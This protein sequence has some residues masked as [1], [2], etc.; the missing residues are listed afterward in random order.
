[1][2]ETKKEEIIQRIIK[3]YGNNADC[4][5]GCEKNC[6]ILTSEI[7]ST[8]KA[9]SESE[10]ID[11]FKDINEKIDEYK[12]ESL[13]EYNGESD[14]SYI[15][16]KDIE[17]LEYFIKYLWLFIYR[18]IKLWLKPKKI[19]STPSSLTIKPKEKVS[20]VVNQELDDYI[21]EY[22]SGNRDMYKVLNEVYGTIKSHS[23]NI[24]EIKTEAQVEYEATKGAKGYKTYDRT[25]KRLMV[26]PKKN[27]KSINAVKEQLYH[28]ENTQTEKVEA[29]DRALEKVDRDIASGNFNNKPRLIQWNTGEFKMHPSKASRDGAR[30]ILGKARN[31]IAGINKVYA[32]R[33]LDKNTEFDLDTKVRVPEKLKGANHINGAFKS[34]QSTLNSGIPVYTNSVKKNG[35]TQDKGQEAVATRLRKI[36]SKK[37]EG[38]ESTYVEVDNDGNIKPGSNRFVLRTHAKPA[39]T[40]TKSY[41]NKTELIARKLTNNEKLSDDEQEYFTNFKTAI[42]AKQKSF[43]RQ[44][45]CVRQK[46]R[47]GSPLVPV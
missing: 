44:R 10:R 32:D 6:T 27:A 11:I 30:S 43:N 41:P 13:L 18:D 5:K 4:L 29:L 34:V 24:K 1:M 8:V 3:K 17:S 26:D 36:G 22:F 25:L 12:P 39:K 7:K 15:K 2:M 46:T 35:F 19:I 21:L 40:N 47:G 45:I 14:K 37:K 38:I 28:F 42:E 23:T 16:E 20:F 31:T 9:Y 33:G